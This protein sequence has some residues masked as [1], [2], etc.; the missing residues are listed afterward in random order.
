MLTIYL[1][2]LDTEQER[3]KMTDIYEVSVRKHRRNNSIKSNEYLKG[4]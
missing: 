4:N 3:K 1:S 2:M